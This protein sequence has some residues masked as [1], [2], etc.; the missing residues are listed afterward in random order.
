MAPAGSPDR[1][2]DREQI[3][4]I[5][6]DAFDNVAAIIGRRD[7]PRQEHINTKVQ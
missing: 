5:V 4:C 2:C 7:G 1:V 3:V 6:L